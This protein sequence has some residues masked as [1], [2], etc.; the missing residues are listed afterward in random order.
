M[1][2]KIQE[3]FLNYARAAKDKQGKNVNKFPGARIMGNWN[4]LSE[5]IAIKKMQAALNDPAWTQVGMDPERHSYFYDR[6][7]TQPILSALWKPAPVKPLRKAS[8]I[9]LSFS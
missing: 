8:N 7:T 9:S 4:P 3:T 1:T 6:K 5:Q 2:P